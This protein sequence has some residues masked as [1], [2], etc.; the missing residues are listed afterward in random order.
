MNVEDYIRI[1]FTQTLNEGFKGGFQSLFIILIISV[2]ILENVTPFFCVHAGYGYIGLCSGPQSTAAIRSMGRR[3][4]GR[5]GAPL[6]LFPCY[7]SLLRASIVRESAW[8]PPYT[9]LPVRCCQ[10]PLTTEHSAYRTIHAVHTMPTIP[11]THSTDIKALAVAIVQENIRLFIF[12]LSGVSA[13]RPPSP[14]Q[15]AGPGARALRVPCRF[16]VVLA[17]ASKKAICNYL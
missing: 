17:C 7:R 15:G 14:R 4:T 10:I 1:N 9:S 12:T 8:R 3:L 5:R 2:V 13:A 16:R 6:S 11:S